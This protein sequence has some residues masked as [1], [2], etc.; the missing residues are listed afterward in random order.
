MLPPMSSV[1]VTQGGSPYFRYIRDHVR[2][3]IA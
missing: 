2:A 3:G 1:D